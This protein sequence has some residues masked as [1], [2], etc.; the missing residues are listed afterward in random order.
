MT[1]RLSS[2]DIVMLTDVERTA[3]LVHLAGSTNPDVAAATFEAVQR[4]LER[5]RLHG[6]PC[7]FPVTDRSGIQ[8]G[9]EGAP[10]S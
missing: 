6:E 9:P 4:V 7:L 8:R 2:I 10:P 1:D 5:T 3:T